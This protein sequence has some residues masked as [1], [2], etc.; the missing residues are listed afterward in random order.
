MFLIFR[1]QGTPKKKKLSRKK[2]TQAP[3]EALTAVT[4]NMHNSEKN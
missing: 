2:G 3:W 4:A 1:E